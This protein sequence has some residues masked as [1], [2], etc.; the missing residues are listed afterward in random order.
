MPAMSL[1]AFHAFLIATAIAFFAA[2]GI[3]CLNYPGGTVYGLMAAASGIVA[4]LMTAYLIYFIQY[5]L[6]RHD[7]TSGPR[8]S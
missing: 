4:V 2:F 5:R 8:T 6:R 1:Y 7:G 3:Y